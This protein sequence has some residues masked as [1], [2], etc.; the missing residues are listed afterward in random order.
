MK[1][2]F[3]IC[4]TFWEYIG[5]WFAWLLRGFY[6]FPSIQNTSTPGCCRTWRVR[7]K[8]SPPP[9]LC[10]SLLLL[11]S[12][13]SRNKKMRCINLCPGPVLQWEIATKGQKWLIAAVRAFK[14]NNQY[15]TFNAHYHP[16]KMISRF[17]WT[18]FYWTLMLL[19]CS[20]SDTYMFCW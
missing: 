20:S 9:I 15:H 18:T 10:S 19:C 4:W 17:Y 5:N 3:W 14:V 11:V 6:F 7:N 8:D 1:Q 16:N 12:H 2:I 13:L